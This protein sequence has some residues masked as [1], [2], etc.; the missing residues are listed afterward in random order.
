[1]AAPSVRMIA[2]TPA[3][4]SFRARGGRHGD[5]DREDRWIPRGSGGRNGRKARPYWGCDHHRGR[6]DG[7]AESP[8]ARG[9]D[10]TQRQG[11]PRGWPG[12]GWREVGR[13]GGPGRPFEAD[14]GRG[15]RAS[16]RR[17]SASGSPRV[18]HARQGPI[19][20]TAHLVTHRRPG[21]QSAATRWGHTARGRNPPA[22]DGAITRR[23]R[24]LYRL[25]K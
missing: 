21:L 3:L 18:R 11:R 12:D 6:S 9:A 22:T 15:H 20:C 4:S 5:G 24:Y 1:M 8:A 14:P 13:A 10:G 2:E 25:D 17:V 23:G 7:G 19:Y 16:Q